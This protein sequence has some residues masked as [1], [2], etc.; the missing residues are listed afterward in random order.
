MVG[1][2]RLFDNIDISEQFANFP[3]LSYAQ[4]DRVCGR[5]VSRCL[6]SH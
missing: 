1:L 6:L 5:K 4:G 2:F 3:T